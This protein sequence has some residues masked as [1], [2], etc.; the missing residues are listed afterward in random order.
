MKRASVNVDLPVVF[1]IINNVEMMINAG[2]N[3][4]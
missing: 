2:V 3:C 1:E 4:R